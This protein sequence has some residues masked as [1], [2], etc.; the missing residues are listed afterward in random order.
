MKFWRFGLFWRWK[1]FV[2]SL[3]VCN[4]VTKSNLNFLR[5]KSGIS[6]LI[7]SGV[8]HNFA[9]PESSLSLNTPDFPKQIRGIHQKVTHKTFKK[10]LQSTKSATELKEI[11]K[12][13]FKNHLSDTVIILMSVNAH[14]REKWE[15]KEKKHLQSLISFGPKS[16][17]AKSQT[18]QELIFIL[19]L[20]AVFFSLWDFKLSP[21]LQ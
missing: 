9:F 10:K 17:N 13:N 3:V 16:L 12:I 5:I 18:D 8:P 6:K 1:L 19:L 7:S 11:P 20:F 15:G 2:N 14:S 21:P 4:C